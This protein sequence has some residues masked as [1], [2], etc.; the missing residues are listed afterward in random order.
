MSNII[1]RDVNNV[2]SSVDFS[3]LKNKSVLITG[4]SGLIGCYLV[5]CLKLVYKKYNI[6]VFLS[7]K[8]ELSDNFKEI[9]DFEYV[10]LQ[11]DI[12]DI[13]LKEK[14]DLIVH[15]AGY[16]QPGKF[17]DNKIKTIEISTTATINLLTI[18]KLLLIISICP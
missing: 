18:F 17:L 11:G 5:A 16:G 14:M 12:M 3:Q 4:A 2:V 7:H 15:A 10:S 8:S 1:E 13:S 6:K 9:F